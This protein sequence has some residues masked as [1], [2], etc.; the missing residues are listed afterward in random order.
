[1]V[2]MRFEVDRARIGRAAGDQ[3]RRAHLEGPGLDLFV[4]EQAARAVHPVVMGVEPA[5]GKVRPGAVAEM[6]ARRNLAAIG[7]QA[8]RRMHRRFRR[9]LTLFRRQRTV[10]G[11]DVT[12]GSRCGGTFRFGM[13][14]DLRKDPR[15]LEHAQ[16]GHSQVAPGWFAA[17]DIHVS[18]VMSVHGYQSL[19]T[20]R[21]SN[22][23]RKLGDGLGNMSHDKVVHLGR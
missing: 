3:Q 15:F 13:R 11:N 8:H 6:P 21:P 14:C 17:M 2:A 5:P 1:M 10:D 16:V 19:Q 4:V 22:K 12:S 9:A 23:P 18:H 7:S 20:R